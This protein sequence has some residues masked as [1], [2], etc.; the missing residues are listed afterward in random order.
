MS[1][2]TEVEIF[3]C[4]TS[5]LKL[6][7][8][9]CVDLAKYP[10]KGHNYKKF[11]EA[12]KL[13]EGSCRQASAWREDTRWLTIGLMMAESHK[14]AGNWLRGAKKPDGTK[15][16]IPE[17]QLQPMFIK[18]GMNLLD[19]LEKTVPALQ[20]KRTNRRGMILPETPTAPRNVSRVSMSKGGIII[21]D[22]VTVQ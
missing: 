11:R 16:I 3:D 6:A 13:V 5:N 7:A 22:G 15:V 20:H 1:D 10:A 12:L 4:L 19:I 8:T 17:G 2:L 9:L 18:L 14:R 21:P